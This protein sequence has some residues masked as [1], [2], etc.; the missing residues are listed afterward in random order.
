M[1]EARDRQGYFQAKGCFPKL[2]N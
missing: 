2:V 1:I